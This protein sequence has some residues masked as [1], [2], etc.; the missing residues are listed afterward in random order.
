MDRRCSHRTTEDGDRLVLGLAR[1]RRGEA[2]RRWHRKRLS[3][4][5]AKRRR[6]Q[7][8]L[9]TVGTGLAQARPTR[10][11]KGGVLSIGVLAGHAWS[12]P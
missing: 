5:R 1:R 8:S 11:T 9:A 3:T 7:E 4:G 2:G 10:L 12:H 6:Q